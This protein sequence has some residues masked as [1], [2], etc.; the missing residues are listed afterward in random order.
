MTT[1][2]EKSPDEKADTLNSQTEAYGPNNCLKYDDR[3]T[4]PLSRS[5]VIKHFCETTSLHGLGLIVEDKQS[6]AR[7]IFNAKRIFLG[8]MFAAC[9]ALAINTLK[10]R[11]ECDVLHLII[12]YYP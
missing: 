12:E 11:F 5:G 6:K 3:T 10:V 7:W 8:L 9:L 2:Q 4:P 1:P